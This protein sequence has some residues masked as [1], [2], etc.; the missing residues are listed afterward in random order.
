MT[1]T[2]EVEVFCEETNAWIVRTPGRKFPAVVIQGDSFSVLF[3][4]AQEVVE[5]AR[6]I[7]SPALIEEAEELRN[8]LWAHLYRYEQVLEQHGLPL[9]YN[10]IKA[11]L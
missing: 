10:R 8:Q 9:P 7:G 11:P 3:S 2:V 4:S 6:R 5:Q 1:K